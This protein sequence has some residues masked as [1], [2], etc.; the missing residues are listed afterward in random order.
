MENRLQEIVV[1]EILSFLLFIGVRLVGKDMRI[2]GG[3]VLIEVVVGSLAEMR[4]LI[5]FETSGG[6]GGIRRGRRIPGV[7]VGSFWSHFSGKGS[8]RKW[9]REG[10][11]NTSLT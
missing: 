5:C 2:D 11:W 8:G 1:V 7:A 6:G 4:K 9:E 3:F 10:M